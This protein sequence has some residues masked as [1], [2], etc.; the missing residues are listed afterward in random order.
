M[1]STVIAIILGSGAVVTFGYLI[2]RDILE[3]ARGDVPP[4]TL[5]R[6]QY[7]L[8]AFGALGWPVV[9]VFALALAIKRRRAIRRR[10]R[11]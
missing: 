3:A 9:A 11:W 5:P 7:G 2:V 1:L 6:P 4:H 8:Y 10:S